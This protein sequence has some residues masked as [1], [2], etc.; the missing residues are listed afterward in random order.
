MDNLSNPA[1]PAAAVG[2]DRQVLFVGLGTMGLPMA[3]NLL[4]AG[5]AVTGYDRLDDARRAFAE[6]GGR[7][8]TDPAEA[9]AAADVVITMVPDDRAIRD[10]LALPDVKERYA[11]QGAIIPDPMS[12]AQLVS[13]LNADI[14]GWRKVIQDA[15]ITAD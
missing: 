1:S 13:F 10:V 2:G 4:R 8:V 3:R 11:S 5:W 9:A 15:K 7:V 6:A 12:Q 14:A